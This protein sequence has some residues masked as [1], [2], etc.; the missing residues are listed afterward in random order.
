VLYHDSIDIGVLN[1]NHD[2]FPHIKCFAYDRMMP[3]ICAD[4]VPCSLEQPD[5][6]IGKSKVLVISH[7]ILR[8]FSRHKLCTSVYIYIMVFRFDYI[9]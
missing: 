9:R 8:I 6:A 5:S 2:I 1:M 4:I 3:M 7:L